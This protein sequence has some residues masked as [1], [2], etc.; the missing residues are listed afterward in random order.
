MT[1]DFE[2][3]CNLLVT[4]TWRLAFPSSMASMTSSGLDTNLSVAPYMNENK[5]VKV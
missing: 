2:E 4:A 5:C 1:I 3:L